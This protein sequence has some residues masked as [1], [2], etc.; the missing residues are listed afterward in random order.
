MAVK[1]LPLTIAELC[2]H[3]LA[4]E[5]HA[6]LRFRDYAARMRKLGDWKVAFAFDEMGRD[7]DDEVRALEAAAGERGPAALSQWEY[8]WRLTYLPEATEGR[9]RLVPMSATEALQLALIAK[10]RAEAYYAEVAA[11][12]GD[13]MVRGCAAEM[14]SAGQRQIRRIERLLAGGP[15]EPQQA[16]SSASGD[17]VLPS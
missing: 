11:S 17:A 13:A 16:G 14:A 1:L 7:Q 12:A 10:R 3:A 4:L 8:V 5:R 15:E 6:G 9:P 2:A